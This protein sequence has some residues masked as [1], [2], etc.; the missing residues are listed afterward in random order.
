MS[1]PARRCRIKYLI[2]L[3]LFSRTVENRFVFG[4]FDVLLCGVILFV[5]LLRWR[6]RVAP[7]PFRSQLFLFLG[8]VA[9]GSSFIVGAVCSGVFLFWGKHLETVALDVFRHSLQICAW[10]LLGA[11]AYDRRPRGKPLSGVPAG[12]MLPCLLLTIPEAKRF[13][14]VLLPGDAHAGLAMDAANLVILGV[15]LALFFRRPLGGRQFGTAGLF[16]FFVAACLHIASGNSATSGS[17]VLWNLEQFAWLLSLFTFAVAIGEAS[18]DLFGKVF[19]RLQIA[20]ILLASLMILVIT[21]TEKAEYLASIRSRSERLVEF[22]RA[23]V[24]HF[25][26][27]NDS[28]PRILE[29][30]DFLQRLTLGFSDLQELK[31]VR[32]FAEGQVAAFE[33]ADNGTIRQELQRSVP[34][35]TPAPLDPDDYFLVETLPFR[36]ARPGEVQFYGRREFLNV[37]ARKRIVLIFSLFSGMVAVSTLMIGLVVRGAGATIRQQAREIQHTQQQLMQASKLAAIGQLAAGVAHEI[38]NPATTILSRTSYLL[39][40]EDANYSE[41]DREDLETV[42]A[43]AQRIAQ[44]TRGLLLFSRPQILRIELVPIEQVVEKSLRSVKDSLAAGRIAVEKSVP[45]DLPRVLADADNLARA[46]EN[47]LRNAIDAMPN[48]GTLRIAA[49]LRDSSRSHLRLAITDTG[50]GI[51][52]EKLGRVFEP[53]FTTKEVGKGTGLGLSIAQGI[54]QEHGGKIEVESQPGVGTTFTINLPVE[55]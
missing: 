4:L 40:Q 37:H 26:K 51:D 44:V 8:F 22:V 6:A 31:I 11:S 18:Q 48:G 47:I 23:H 28:L 50:I 3:E 17:V 24:D 42:V 12:G 41:S 36:I 20:F 35:V 15:V 14:G 45:G 43:Q 21:Q 46:L 10:A 49:A 7:V 34:G 5:I 16:L 19:V 32:I 53:F 55:Q 54:I 39:S 27:E 33:I 30:E 38:N 29:R 25:R 2:Q 9:L 1:D 52:S 13:L